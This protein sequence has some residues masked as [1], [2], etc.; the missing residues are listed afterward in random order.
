MI[1][2]IPLDQ[3]AADWLA[4]LWFLNGQLPDNFRGLFTFE[5]ELEVVRISW[6]VNL[7]RCHDFYR[8]INDCG[9]FTSRKLLGSC[10]S[11]NA[12]QRC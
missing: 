9:R 12:T 1:V 10:L 5:V 11:K 8:A 6:I 3:D 7:K 2:E 4:I